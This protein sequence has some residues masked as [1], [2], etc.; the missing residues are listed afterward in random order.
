MSSKPP[1]LRGKAKA[2]L[3]PYPLGEFPEDVIIQIGSNIVHRL[4][5][6]YSDITGDEF[7]GIFAKAIRGVHRQKPLGV[8]DVVHDECSWSAKTVKCAKPF[9][10]ETIRLIMGRNDVRYSYGIENVSE[11]I[12]V[13]GSSVLKIWNERVDQSFN[14]FSELRVVVLVRDMNKLEFVL[15]EDEALRYIPSNYV[16]EA[17]QKKNF[18]AFEKNTRKHRFTWQPGGKQFTVIKTIPASAY[19]F[20]IKRR[21]PLIDPQTIL[22]HA[23]FNTDWIE[24]IE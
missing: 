2:R 13:T 21:P 24:R 8:T 15:F 11:D 4:A 16:W 3:S 12:P 20:R 10:K 22:S 19:K 6:G 9:E 23:G 18:E 14:E 5:V 7:A 1:K 17:N